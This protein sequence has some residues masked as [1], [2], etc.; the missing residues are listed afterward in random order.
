MLELFLHVGSLYLDDLLELKDQKSLSLPSER[1]EIML[2]DSQSIPQQEE[3][4]HMGMGKL[5]SPALSPPPFFH[6]SNAR[7]PYS[8]F[9]SRRN[10]ASPLLAEKE[11]PLARPRDMSAGRTEPRLTTKME[12]AKRSVSFDLLF[13]PVRLFSKRNGLVF[14]FE[15]FFFSLTFTQ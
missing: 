10:P 6:L 8:P 12:R 11:E 9:A 4:I 15:S 2:K 1:E 3:Q 5:H 13:P 14:Y 7:S